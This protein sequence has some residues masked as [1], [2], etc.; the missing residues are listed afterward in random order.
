MIFACQKCMFFWVGKNVC[1]KCM[2]RM[3]FFFG[4]KTMHVQT[5]LNYH[6]ECVYGVGKTC[7]SKMHAFF[8]DEK[9]QKTS[10]KCRA[11]SQNH[12]F[13]WV[14]FKVLD[15]CSEFFCPC[16]FALHFGG[17]K[18]AKSPEKCSE[19]SELKACRR[20]SE[21]LCS[22]FSKTVK[23]GRNCHSRSLIDCFMKP[24]S[25]SDTYNIN[26]LGEKKLWFVSLQMEQE[27]SEHRAPEVL[28]VEIFIANSIFALCFTA[29][30]IVHWDWTLNEHSCKVK[31]NIF[32]S[33]CPN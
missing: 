23:I 7:M 29:N 28:A 21:K 6:P 10:K 1:P 17:C 19:N 12:N 2:F 25:A 4:W 3:R 11:A 16:I 15:V 5:E 8:G 31:T 14:V 24:N 13:P 27:L 33:S 20:S 30:E 22:C 26:N 32:Q 18:I 9:L